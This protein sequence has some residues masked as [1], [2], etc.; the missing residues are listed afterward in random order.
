MGKGKGTGT[1]TGKGKT[2]NKGKDEGMSIHWN[3]PC[4][5]CFGL[6]A[7]STTRCAR[8]RWL[9]WAVWRPCTGG[10]S[11]CEVSRQWW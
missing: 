1:G 10:I 7:M 9:R 2:K 8:L 4:M 6:Q 5:R 3:P 11:M